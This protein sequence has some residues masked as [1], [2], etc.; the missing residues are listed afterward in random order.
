M[1]VDNH[2]SIAYTCFESSNRAR[3]LR[4]NVESEAAVQRCSQG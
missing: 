2:I 4:E 1:R 3:A